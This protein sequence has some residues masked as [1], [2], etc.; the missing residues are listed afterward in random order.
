MNICK[1]KNR[2]CPYAGSINIKGEPMYGDSPGWHEIPI[3]WNDAIDRKA[4]K[5][6]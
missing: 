6:K 4:T 1:I 5:C 2:E 3:C